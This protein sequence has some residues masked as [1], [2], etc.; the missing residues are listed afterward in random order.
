MLAALVDGSAIRIIYDQFY[1]AR[2][3]GALLVNVCFVV[4]RY[5]KTTATVLTRFIKNP[6]L[7]YLYIYIYLS[8]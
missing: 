8:L 1:A 6:V 7:F 2:V 3:S 4:T 5:Y